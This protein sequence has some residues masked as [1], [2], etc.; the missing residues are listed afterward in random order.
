[1]KQKKTSKSSVHLSVLSIQFGQSYKRF[2]RTL[3]QILTA[4]QKKIMKLPFLLTL[5]LLELVCSYKVLVFNPAFGASHSNFLGK[6]SDILID[7]GHDVVSFL[8]S[9]FR[10][11][12]LFFRQC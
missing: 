11:D 12:L 1:M 9:I 8:H 10:H 4:K 5:L 3:V 7:A 2:N 6:I